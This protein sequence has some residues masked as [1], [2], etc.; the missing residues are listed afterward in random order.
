M[1]YLNRDYCLYVKT[2]KKNIKKPKLGS[3]SYKI[4]AILI[5]NFIDR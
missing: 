3:F 1:H 5:I 4:I 2:L